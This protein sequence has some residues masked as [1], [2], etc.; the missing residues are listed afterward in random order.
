MRTFFFFMALLATPAVAAAS[1]APLTAACRMVGAQ[2]CAENG[3]CISDMIRSDLTI[4]FDIKKGRYSSH[5]GKGQIKEVWDL[6]DGSHWMTL[7]SPPA[8]VEIRFIANWREA[9]IDDGRGGRTT[10][11]C[12]LTE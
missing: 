5:L 2:G 7:S 9:F 6:P 8:H 3:V 12:A 4:K 11:K 1:Q 10:Y